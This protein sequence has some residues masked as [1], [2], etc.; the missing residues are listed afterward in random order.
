MKSPSVRYALIRDTD[1]QVFT[2]QVNAAMKDGWVPVG[3]V[4]C[5]SEAP[6]A[7]GRDTNQTAY[8][9]AMIIRGING[10]DIVT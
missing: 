10:A 7:V 4:A 5:V 2:N 6:T 3:G 1:P 8:C 9:Q